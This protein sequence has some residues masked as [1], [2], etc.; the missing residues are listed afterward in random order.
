MFVV[1]DGLKES[2]ILKEYSFD[3]IIADIRLQ[4]LGGIEVIEEYRNNGGQAIVIAHTALQQYEHHKEVFNK[5]IHKPLSKWR[6]VLKEFGF[7]TT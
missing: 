5:V 3:L 6:D 4:G 2:V 1:D 7:I